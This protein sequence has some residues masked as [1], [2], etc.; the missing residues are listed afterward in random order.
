L[1]ERRRISLLFLRFDLAGETDRVEEGPIR[2]VWL[3]PLEL[4]RFDE[5][6]GVGGVDR[7]A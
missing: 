2:E 6:R 4:D 1:S 5:I 3:V 7:I